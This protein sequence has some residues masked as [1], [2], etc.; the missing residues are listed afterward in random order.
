[1]TLATLYALM[2]W[3][4]RVTSGATEVLVTEWNG[5]HRLPMQSK[6]RKWMDTSA[7]QK[8]ERKRK[9]ATER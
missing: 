3:T 9:I 1:M 5:A 8:T 7:G 4:H 2:D 6:N